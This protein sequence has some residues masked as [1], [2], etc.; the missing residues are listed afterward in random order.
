MLSV[1][2][3]ADADAGLAAIANKDSMVARRQSIRITIPPF[4]WQYVLK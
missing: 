1:I 4:C 2:E 3:G